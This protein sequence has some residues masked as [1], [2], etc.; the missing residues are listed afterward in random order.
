VK[1]FAALSVSRPSRDVAMHG[2]LEVF[3]LAKRTVDRAR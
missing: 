1:R 3:S 2:W